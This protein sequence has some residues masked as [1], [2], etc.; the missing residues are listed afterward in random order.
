M[1]VYKYVHMTSSKCCW[2]LVSHELT[3]FTEISAPPPPSLLWYQ[4]QGQL[5][6]VIAWFLRCGPASHAMWLALHLTYSMHDQ[7]GL[8]LVYAT[9]FSVF[10]Y[11]CTC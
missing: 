6:M 9:H 11:I 2:G 7:I 8:T 5:P 4:Q 1:Q 10:M 3:V